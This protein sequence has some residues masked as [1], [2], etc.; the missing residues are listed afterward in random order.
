MEKDQGR[1]KYINIA[2]GLVMV[3]VV[4]VHSFV[5]E[6]RGANSVVMM[7][8]FWIAT[9]ILQTFMVIS[10]YLF[11]RGYPKYRARGGEVFFLGKLQNLMLPYL[12]MSVLSYVGIGFAFFIPPLAR[13]LHSGGYNEFG[14][15]EAVFQ[16]VTYE[17]H[18]INH[19]WFLPTLFLIFVVSYLTGKFFAGIPGLFVSLAVSV[20]PYFLTM[21]TL[22][23]R[24]C[25]MLFFFNIGRQ[26]VFVE[27]ISQKRWFAPLLIVFIGLFAVQRTGL[28]SWS[29]ILE[30]LIAPIIGVAGAMTLFALSRIIENSTVGRCASWIGDNSFAIYL[31][32]QPFI[33]SGVSGIL[34]MFTDLPHLVICSITLVLGIFIPSA[35]NKYIFGRVKLLRGLLLGDFSVKAE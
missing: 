25:S 20:L 6:I 26:I 34:L 13:V 23:Y 5:P 21:P 12:S 1:L 14:L 3:F 4:M 7:L 9:F 29:P 11:E 10:G 30:V 8:F 17:G 35:I 31:L 33:V 27:G 32:H 19:L 22:A 24:V 28:L 18:I 2:R 15:G 16:I